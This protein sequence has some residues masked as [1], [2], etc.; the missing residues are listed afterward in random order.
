MLSEVSS[1]SASSTAS[2]TKSLMVSSPQG[3]SA[4]R[5]NPP[6]NPFTP[7]KPTPVDLEGVA[8]IEH[9]DA[10]IARGSWLSS[11]TFADS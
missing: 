5:P 1:F 10:G 4:R 6:A 8:A 7:A 3:P 2:R 9:L 11:G